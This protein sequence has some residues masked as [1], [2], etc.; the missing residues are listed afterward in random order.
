ME[1]LDPRGAWSHIL[2]EPGAEGAQTTPTDAVESSLKIQWDDQYRPT[3][4]VHT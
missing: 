2:S 3:L 1:E 4:L